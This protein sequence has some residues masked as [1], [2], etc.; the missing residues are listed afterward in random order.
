MGGTAA[1]SHGPD[2]AP[3]FTGSDAAA[4]GM[5]MLAINLTCA[6]IGAGAGALV[7]ALV[8]LT[9]VGFLIGFGLAIT[10]V[11]KRFRGV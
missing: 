10:F 11:I 5:L 7:G 8:P 2:E 9:A 3:G 1:T 4:A 6:A